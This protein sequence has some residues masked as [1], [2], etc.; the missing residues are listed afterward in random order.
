MS[1]SK[2][3]ALSVIALMMAMSET[4]Q[5]QNSIHKVEIKSTEEEIALKR[6]EAEDKINM[7]K[8]LTKWYFLGGSVWALNMKNAVRK[9][10]KL[11]I[12]SKY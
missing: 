2:Q 8:G 1:K 4:E 5:Q 9:A 12:F 6:Q 10:K 11:G 7:S 3:K